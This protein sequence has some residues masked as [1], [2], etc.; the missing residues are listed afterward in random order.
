MPRKGVS[1][2]EKRQ[3]L[4]KIVFVGNDVFNLKQLE[5][6][7]KKAGIVQQTV[8]D[9]AQSLVDDNMID[10]DKVGSQNIYWGFAS[11]A[12]QKLAAKKAALTKSISQH[13]SSVRKMEEQ[14][15]ELTAGRGGGE[16]RTA[17]VAENKRLA[18]EIREL[19]SQLGAHQA[20]DPALLAELEKKI[21]IAKQGAER[22]TDNIFEL[23]SKC[24]KKF[25]QPVKEMNK[26]M[27]ISDEFDY[28]S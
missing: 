16:E 17:T 27:G 18:V 28:L 4:K 20:N 22:W 2:E 14:S 5:K 9:V 26:H 24:V 3:R 19:S 23:R 10:L 7:G 12:T 8:K 25:N 13:Q 21:N 1:W 11:K 6:R 15:A